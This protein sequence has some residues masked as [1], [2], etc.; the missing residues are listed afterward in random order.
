MA[1]LRRMCSE[2]GLFLPAFP[3]DNGM[4]LSQLEHV[5]TSP[6]RFLLRLRRNLPNGSIKPLGTR[7]LDVTSD[8]EVKVDE[9]R[10]VPGGRYLFT[11]SART[12]KLWDIG[13]QAD[14]PMKDVPVA[15]IHSAAFQEYVDFSAMQP[16]VGGSGFRMVFQASLTDEM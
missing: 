4:S 5:V 13:F 8:P 7:I 14:M 15:S 2:H 16:T 1:A 12:V 9:M 10:L 3:I 6:A 11:L